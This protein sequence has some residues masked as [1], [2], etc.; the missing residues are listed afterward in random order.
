LP[1]RLFFHR[2]RLGGY[3]YPGVNAVGNC[4]D[5]HGIADRLRECSLHVKKV[6]PIMLLAGA[7]SGN[8]LSAAEG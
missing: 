2:Q 8:D 5:K 4:F 3:K 1:K 7:G 6:M